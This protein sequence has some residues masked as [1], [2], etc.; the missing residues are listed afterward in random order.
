V[1]H[2]PAFLMDMLP[3]HQPRTGLEAKYSIEY[4]LV[5]VALDGRAGMHQY[6]DAAVNRPAARDLLTRV[7]YVPVEGQLGEVKLESH[8]VVTLKDGTKLEGTAHESHGN[9]RDPLTEA[10]VAAKFHECTEALLS[11][12]QRTAVMD[13]CYQ[14]DTL[15][16]VRI[17]GDAV[18]LISA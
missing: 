18:S 4:D 12:E 1:V 6:T 11:E 10:E 16:S 8:V 14:L 5:A 13:L 2:L 15:P 9:P 17:L 3:Y 7:R